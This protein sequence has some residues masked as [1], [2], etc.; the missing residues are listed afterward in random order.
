[1]QGLGDFFAA[2]HQASFLTTQAQIEISDKEIEN[3]IQ[4]EANNTITVPLNFFQENRNR[5]A[6][7]MF[8]KLINRIFNFRAYTQRGHNLDFL[9]RCP[10]LY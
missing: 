8:I 10:R 7:E 4:K 3:K 1:V 9:G 6:Q 2:P 5:V